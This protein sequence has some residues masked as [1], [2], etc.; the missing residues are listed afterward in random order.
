MYAFASSAR[1]VL[2]FVLQATLAIGVSNV[3]AQDRFSFSADGAQVTDE[4]TGLIWRRC[5]GGQIYANGT[6]TNEPRAYS[7]L[8]AIEYARSQ[9]GWR[10][11]N[12]KE[13]FSLVQFGR[14]NPFIDSAAF[15]NTSFAGYYLTS[16]PFFG[17]GSSHIY[18]NGW[19]YVSFAGGDLSQVYN[20][21]TTYHVRL[22]R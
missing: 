6:C 13:L 1:K 19:Y 18:I 17:Y 15:P 12:V 2:L 14:T 9:S 16:T 11:P 21:P 5:S 8:Q 7:F 20:R 4:Y 22:V 10:L 3:S